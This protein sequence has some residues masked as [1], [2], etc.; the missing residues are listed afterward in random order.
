MCTTV[1]M[2]VLNKCR[3]PGQLLHIDLWNLQPWVGSV[4]LKTWCGYHC[5][6]DINDSST[7]IF[8]TIFKW[9]FFH[10][11][12]HDVT[13]ILAYLNMSFQRHSTPRYSWNTANIGIKDQS[14][15]DMVC[16][17]RYSWDTAK[18]GIKH[19]SINQR[20]GPLIFMI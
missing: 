7:F 12:S 10:V 11:Q 17:D 20:Y 14:I 3:K 6:N 18:V 9:I 15:K 19:Q 2:F 1:R 4:N 16:H 13:C 5:A 8:H